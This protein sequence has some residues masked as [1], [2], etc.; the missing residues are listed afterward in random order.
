MSEES[1]NYWELLN[2][3]EGL[4]LLRKG[5]T[6]ERAEIY[7]FT[8]SST[9]ETVSSKENDISEKF[10]KLMLCLWKLDIN[11]DIKLH[12]RHVAGTKMMMERSDGG[13][14]G[15]LSQGAMSSTL[16]LNLFLCI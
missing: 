12:I 9:T 2:L 11:T 4:E 13:S 6:L 8:P 14:R 1:S 3:V 15:D 7:C 5:G 10:L 16:V